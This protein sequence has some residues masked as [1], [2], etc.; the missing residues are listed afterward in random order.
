MFLS[1]ESYEDIDRWAET[2][3]PNDYKVFKTWLKEN[4]VYIHSL[5]CDSPLRSKAPVKISAHAV[6]INKTQDETKRVYALLCGKTN[7][8]RLLRFPQ[9]LSKGH[10]EIFARPG[11]DSLQLAE[12]FTWLHTHGANKVS[13]DNITTFVHYMWLAESIPCPDILQVKNFKASF[14]KV[15]GDFA[16]GLDVETQISGTLHHL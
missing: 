3:M 6:V 12:P 16:I 13:M 4:K 7:S 15:I 9:G 1:G 8:L 14:S 11:I 2:T 5:E 10:A